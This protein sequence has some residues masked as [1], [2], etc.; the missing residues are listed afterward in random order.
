M[1]LNLDRTM[2]GIE[3]LLSDASAYPVIGTLAGIGKVMIGATQGIT[4]LAYGVLT[5]IPCA[6]KRDPTPL[7]H[8]WTHI[9]HGIGNMAAG[10]LEA[11]PLVQ[12]AIYWIRELKQHGGS[13][14]IARLYTGQENKFMPYSSLEEHDWKIVT[15][16]S[17]NDT[18]AAKAIDSIFK[19][20]YGTKSL[21]EDATLKIKLKIA[22]SMYKQ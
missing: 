10:T 22:K 12:T 19:E 15:F 21:S 16:E 17:N 13:D 18:D 11:I 3:N 7:K 9:K 14:R 4:A 8:S 1:G 2:N 6:I 5:A 20:Q